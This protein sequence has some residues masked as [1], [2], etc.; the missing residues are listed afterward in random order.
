MFIPV[1][2][3]PNSFLLVW[4]GTMTALDDACVVDPFFRSN[5]ELSSTWMTPEYTAALPPCDLFVGSFD[6]LMKVRGNRHLFQVTCV[7]A[8]VLPLSGA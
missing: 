5:F 2:R 1:Q 6:D 3:L 7:N 8:N 4:R